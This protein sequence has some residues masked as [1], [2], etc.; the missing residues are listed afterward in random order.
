MENYNTKFNVSRYDLQL[1]TCTWYWEGGGPGCQIDEMP[2]T[3][4]ESKLRINDIK[5]PSTLEALALEL[6]MKEIYKHKME[7]TRHPEGYAELY[8]KDLVKKVE[9]NPERYVKN[10]RQLVKKCL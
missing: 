2:G 10:L 7:I 3:F 8:H 5:N 6:R 1:E 4:L 9:N